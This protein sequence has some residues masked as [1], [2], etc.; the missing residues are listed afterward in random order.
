[1]VM[2]KYREF[3]SNKLSEKTNIRNVVTSQ[4]QKLTRLEMNTI[5]YLHNQGIEDE[6]Y[7]QRLFSF[8]AK[9]SMDGKVDSNFANQVYVL[10]VDWPVDFIVDYIGKDEYSKL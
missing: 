6:I 5:I 7:G 4:H 8:C 9:L 3:S 10:S 1:M 2:R